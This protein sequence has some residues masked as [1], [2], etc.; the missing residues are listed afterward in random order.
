MLITIG[1]TVINFPESA[2]NPN[3]ADQVILFAQAVESTLAGI[4]SDFD[5]PQRVMNFDLNPS[6]TVFTPITDG[7][8]PLQF[9]T[10]IFPASGVRAA[11][12]KYAIYRKSD[13][14]LATEA[15]SITAIYNG[16]SWTWNDDGVGSNSFSGANSAKASGV[17]FN[18]TAAGQV[19]MKFNSGTALTGTNQIARITYSAQTLKQS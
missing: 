3:W 7:V 8:T 6:P 19:E 15:G 2:N 1:N 13:T 18:I 16:S 9:P 4:V 14:E 11:F 5:I 10:A 12:I 17:E